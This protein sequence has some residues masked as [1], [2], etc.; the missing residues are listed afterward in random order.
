MTVSLKNKQINKKGIRKDVG[1]IGRVII[2]GIVWEMPRWSKKSHK[3]L[4][5]IADIWVGI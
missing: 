1:R 5:R 3:T 2:S 4:V